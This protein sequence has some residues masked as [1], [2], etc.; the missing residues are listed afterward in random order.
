MAR[1]TFDYRICDPKVKIITCIPMEKSNRERGH[2]CLIGLSD[3]TTTI[4]QI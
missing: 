4:V 3:G 1:K 2:K